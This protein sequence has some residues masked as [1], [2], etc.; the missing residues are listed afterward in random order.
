MRPLVVRCECPHCCSPVVQA[1]NAPDPAVCP[2]CYQFFSLPDRQ[3][4]PAWIFGVLAVLMGSL[5]VGV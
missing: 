5:L 3:K 2:Y 4:V 1:A